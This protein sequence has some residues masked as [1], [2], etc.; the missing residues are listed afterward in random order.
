M[1]AIFADSL[2]SL[3]GE[4]GGIGS[5]RDK[6][7]Q[8]HYDFARISQAEIWALME[9]SWIAA[10]AVEQ[11][12]ADMTAR[13]RTWQ[14]RS[15][16]VAAIEA[17]EQRLDLQVKVAKALALAARDGGSLLLIGVGGAAGD[18]PS[19]PLNPSLVGKGD[20]SFIHVASRYEISCGL[21]ERDPSLPWAGLPREY[22]LALDDRK[23]LAIHPT[24][25]C[26]FTGSPAL[27]WSNG[28]P[29]GTSVLQR[30]WRP[31]ADLEQTIRAIQH[32]LFESK[33]D[34]ISIE[35]LNR[36][37]MDPVARTALVSRFALAHSMRSMFSLTLLDAAEKHET[38]QLDLGAGLPELVDRLMIQVCGSVDIP[39]SRLFGRSSANGLQ[40]SAAGESDDERY[41]GRLASKQRTDIGPALRLLDDCLIRSAL[42]RKPRSNSVFYEWAPLWSERATDLA[43]VRLKHAQAAAALAA[44]GLVA[45]TA[46]G[47]SLVSQTEDDGWLPAL[48]QHIAAAGRGAGTTAGE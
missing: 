44:T 23:F 30:A 3:V 28:E 32:L 40:A 21:V 37:V 12:A 31:I 19:T 20:L 27:G 39:A 13:W 35:G 22:R 48:A 24:R 2:R 33:Q 9:S 26:L 6:G 34:I 8:A 41:F 4:M 10:R 11:P 16:D 36:I 17:E 29:W 15:S 43:E 7:S 5:P 25:T 1:N 38:K 42:G 47:A 14:G 18:D 46:L 45:P